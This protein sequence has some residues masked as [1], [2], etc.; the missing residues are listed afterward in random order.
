MIAVEESVENEREALLARELAHFEANRQEYVRQHLG[1]FVVIQGERLIGVY[2]TPQAAYEAAVAELGRE[3]FLIR[4][5][6]QGDQPA[7]AP[8]LYTGLVSLQP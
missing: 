5:V 7:Q 3:L 6:T 1:K 8:A 2:D 4:Q